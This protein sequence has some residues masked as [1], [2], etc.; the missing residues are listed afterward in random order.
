MLHRR[1]TLPF[2]PNGMRFTAFAEPVADSPSADGPE[3]S[4][5]PTPLRER[6]Y[7]SVGGGFVVDEGAAGADRIRAD[8]TAAALPVHH[9]RPSCAP[10]AAATGCRSQG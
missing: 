3:A 4:E 5:E 6:T 7:Y 8:D 10:T 9:R 2:H 1:L